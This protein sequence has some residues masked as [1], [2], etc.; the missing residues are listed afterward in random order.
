[1]LAGTQYGVDRVVIGVVAP[2]TRR[3]LDVVAQVQGRPVPHEAAARSRALPAGDAR[4]HE[5]ERRPAVAREPA[6][7]PR[8]LPVPRPPRVVAQPEAF[9]PLPALISDDDV[10][11]AGY[12]LLVVAAGELLTCGLAVAFGLPAEHRRDAGE[13]QADR[14]V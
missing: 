5:S 8:G 9:D 1:L 3:D 11:G 12:E 4:R 2:P 13:P 14:R 10:T 6:V 7:V